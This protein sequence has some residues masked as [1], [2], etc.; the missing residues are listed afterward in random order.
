MI[1]PLDSSCLGEPT[2]SYPA[3]LTTAL[4]QH[5]IIDMHGATHL[6]DIDH[7]ERTLRHCVDV[8]GATLLNLYLHRFPAVT[9]LTGVTGVAVLAESHISI[10]TWPEHDYAALDIFVCGVLSPEPA[11]ALLKQ[12]F[13]TDS[14]TIIRHRRGMMSQAELDA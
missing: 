1:S 13:A 14:V 7:I 3:H 11:I 10:H 4:G 8:C 5:L 6:T 12:A 2:A 9:G